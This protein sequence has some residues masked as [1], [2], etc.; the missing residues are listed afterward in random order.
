MGGSDVV[1]VE[2]CGWRELVNL[3]Y[4][5]VVQDS[6]ELEAFR[7]FSSAVLDR[8]LTRMNGGEMLYRVER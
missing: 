8:Q 3:W 5:S 4:N 7:R 1:S 6:L 2:S